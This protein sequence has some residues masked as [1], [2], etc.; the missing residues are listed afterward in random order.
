LRIPLRFLERMTTLIV[1]VVAQMMA[2]A[3]MGFM[4][5]M[6]DIPPPMY[7]RRRSCNEAQPR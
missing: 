3:M 1:S 2:I 4:E 6:G 7:Y 5:R